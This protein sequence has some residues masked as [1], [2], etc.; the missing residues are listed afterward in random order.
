M[1]LVYHKELVNKSVIKENSLTWVML[2]EYIKA[3]KKQ[4]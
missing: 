4:I 1:G 2:A 3:G